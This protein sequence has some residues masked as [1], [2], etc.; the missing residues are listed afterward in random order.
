[1]EN[2]RGYPFIGRLIVAFYLLALL[3]ALFTFQA[4][5]ADPCW[6]RNTIAVRLDT[7][8]ATN[9]KRLKGDELAAAARWFNAQEPPS[10]LALALIITADMPNGAGL[11]LLGKDEERACIRLMIP[12]EQWL[13]V[14]LNML[15]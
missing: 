1:M 4:N 2:P 3:V 7:L 14:K 5:A 9:P 12:P 15:G 13:K 8:S 10:E 6:E 11:I